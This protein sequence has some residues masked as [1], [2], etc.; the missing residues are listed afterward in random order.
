MRAQ[1]Q[2]TNTLH[3][4]DADATVTKIKG[5]SNVA[6]TLNSKD[7]LVYNLDVVMATMLQLRDRDIKF[8]TSSQR[9]YYHIKFTIFY[10][11]SQR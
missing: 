8:T 1:H 7:N 10:Q 3:C 9:Q 2:I 5:S 11:L 4:S 6:S